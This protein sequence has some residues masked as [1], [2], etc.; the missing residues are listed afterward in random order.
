MKVL[1]KKRA[2]KYKP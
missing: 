1:Y 2:T